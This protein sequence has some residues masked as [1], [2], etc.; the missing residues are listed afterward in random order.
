MK[1]NITDFFNDIKGKKIAFC[2]LG[3]S[4]L[5]LVKL[6]AEKGMDI[7]ACDKV[8]ENNACSEIKIR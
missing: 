3:V 7:L 5:P 6:I 1:K 2:G 4:N 8:D